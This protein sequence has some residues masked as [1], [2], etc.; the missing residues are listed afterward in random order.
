MRDA[1]F[2][3]LERHVTG[4][5]D[6]VWLKA[7]AAGEEFARTPYTGELFSI[8]H[9]AMFPYLER[10]VCQALAHRA[11]F[12]ETAPHWAPELPLSPAEWEKMIGSKSNQITVVGYF[13]RSLA[14][15]EWNIHL[16]FRDYAC[17]LMACEHTPKCIRTDPDLLKEFSPNPSLQGL[18]SSLCWGVHAR[19]IEFTQLLMRNE[20]IWY[21][22]GM[23][24]EAGRMRDAIEL[25]MKLDR[26]FW[27]LSPIA[28]LDEHRLD[29]RF[30][31]L[32]HS[33]TPRPGCKRRTQHSPLRF[34]K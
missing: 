28:G 30:G 11:S 8:H 14:C 23:A 24:D 34:A 20:E 4:M 17:G 12:R 16:S 25:L 32:T 27:I 13:G 6:V 7:E 9:E 22:C 26:D 15:A 18:D 2:Q 19:I 5:F 3:K 1:F 31:E 10:I 29:H 33:A 21:G